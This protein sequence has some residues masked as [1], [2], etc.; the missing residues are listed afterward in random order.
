MTTDAQHPRPAACRGGRRLDE[1]ASTPHASRCEP[2]R[3]PQIG[4]QTF[5]R[6]RKHR[7]MAADSLVLM[8]ETLLTTGAE[9]R[10]GG[11][12][13]DLIVHVDADTFIEDGTPGETCTSRAPPGCT[14]ETA[15]RLGCDA[16]LVRIIERDGRVLSVGRRRRTVSPALRR[17]LHARDQ[18]SQLPRLQPHARHRRPPHQTLGRR[19]RDQALQPRQLCRRHHRLLH[20]GGYTVEPD[21]RLQIP[22]QTGL[23]HPQGAQAA[24]RPRGPTTQPEPQTRARRINGETCMSHL[25]GERMDHGMGIDGLLQ[26]DWLPL[27]TPRSVGGGHAAIAFTRERDRYRVENG[28]WPTI[29]HHTAPLG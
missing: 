11:A 21:G 29:G 14:P 13:V 17:A 1:R 4:S 19:R 2:H 9:Q 20:E 8:A 12:R 24:G 25:R 16:G 10:N 5:P 7:T 22:P 23:G 26:A 6:K 15:R 28:E 3:V 18:V 27:T